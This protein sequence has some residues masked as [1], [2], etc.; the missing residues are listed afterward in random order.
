ML[1]NSKD[2]AGF[3]KR[4]FA[5]FDGFRV[6]KFVHFARDNFYPNVPLNEALDKFQTLMF[7]EDIRKQEPIDQL[8]A[9]RDLD[10]SRALFQSS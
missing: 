4:F 1:K 2:L 9:L 3:R 8:K 7:D 10:R 6:L 5:W